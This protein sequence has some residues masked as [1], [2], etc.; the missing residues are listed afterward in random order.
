MISLLGE[1]PFDLSEIGKG[2]GLWTEGL[3]VRVNSQPP[4]RENEVFC[5]P[6][7]HQ[8]KPLRGLLSVMSNI[9]SGSGDFLT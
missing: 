7:Q 2:T 6:Q 9:L 1:L 5:F 8:S 4:D 3:R